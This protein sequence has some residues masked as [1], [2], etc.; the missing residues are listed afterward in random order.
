METDAAAYGGNTK[1]L[2]VDWRTGEE[3]NLSELIFLLSYLVN[4]PNQ[5]KEYRQKAQ[6]RVMKKYSWDVDPQITQINAD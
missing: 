6:E 4:N 5:V 3:S 2:P 1:D